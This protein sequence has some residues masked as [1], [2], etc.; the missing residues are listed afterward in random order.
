MPHPGPDQLTL[1]P[2]PSPSNPSSPRTW[3]CTICRAEVASLRHTVDLAR[4]E[5]DLHGILGADRVDLNAALAGELFY[6]DAPAPVVTAAIARL[7]P[8]R[9]PVFAGVPQKIA[10]HHRP[11]TYVVCAEDRAVHPNLQRAMAL[12]ARYRHEWRT[13]HSPALSC[14]DTGAALIMDLVASLNAD[15]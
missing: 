14:P 15:G 11:S 4:A 13:G 8:V 9:R 7:R 12:R 3:P 2:P 10:W 6:A 1:A 5:M